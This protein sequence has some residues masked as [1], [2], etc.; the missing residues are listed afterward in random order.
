MADVTKDNSEQ[1][2]KKKTIVLLFEKCGYEVK[3]L[4]GKTNRIFNGAEFL[5]LLLYFGFSLYNAVS[6][7]GAGQRFSVVTLII[8]G[9]VLSRS[10]IKYLKKV[11]TYPFVYQEMLEIDWNYS[12]ATIKSGTF[13]YDKK[14]I[15]ISVMGATALMLCIYAEIFGYTVSYDPRAI[16]GIIVVFTTFVDGAVSILENMYQAAPIQ[17]A[18][19]EK[20]T[21][22]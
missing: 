8:N 9:L 11:Y 16:V 7:I 17:Y 2:D 10:W 14:L 1:S 5:L 3:D 18:I 4:T 19:L 12:N 20:R 13:V 15:F 21:G 6:G 22:R